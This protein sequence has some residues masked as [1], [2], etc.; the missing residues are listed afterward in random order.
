[1]TRFLF[2]SRWLPVAVL[3][4]VCSVTA[5]AQ[6]TPGSGGPVPGGTPDPTPVPLDGGAALL[7]AGGAAYA[8]RRLRRPARA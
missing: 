3:M 8:L 6:G 5:Q 1:M 7:L 2:L 4:V